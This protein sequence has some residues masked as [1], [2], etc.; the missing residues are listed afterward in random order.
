MWSI[1]LLTNISLSAVVAV[2]FGLQ[3]WS[4]N[5]AALGRFLKTIYVPFSDALWLLAEALSRLLF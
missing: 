3:A 4:H 5:N 1:S 2:S